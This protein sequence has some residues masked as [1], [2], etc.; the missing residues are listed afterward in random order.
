[1]A[2]VRILNR[3]SVLFFFRM[4]TCWPG[5]ERSCL[6]TLQWEILAHKNFCV[7]CRISSVILGSSH[8][9]PAFW[10]QLWGVLSLV[11]PPPNLALSWTQLHALLSHLSTFGSSRLWA[12][13]ALSDISSVWLEWMYCTRWISC[14]H[15]LPHEKSRHWASFW[16]FIAICWWHFRDHS[17]YLTNSQMEANSLF[18][19]LK[20][21]ILL[22]S[23][24]DQKKKKK[25]LHAYVLRLQTG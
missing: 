7:N 25:S 13:T 24:P 19:P 15:S 16:E 1:M 2:W 11:L 5:M 14:F 20:P 8:K 6:I 4:H 23:S 17:A 12:V 22:I 21:K 10:P 9:D 3:F 18:W